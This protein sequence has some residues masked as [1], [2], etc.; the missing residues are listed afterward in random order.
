M[1]Q[2]QPQGRP[3]S[4]PDRLIVTVA[5]A[6]WIAGTLVG[7]G[8][9]GQAPDAAQGEGLFSDHA[10][11]LAPYRPAFSIWPVIYVFLAGY[12]VWQWLPVAARSRWAAATRWPAAASLALNGLWLVVVYQGWIGGSVVVMAALLVS[13]GVLVL[14]L[15]ALP[16]EG[17]SS[18]VFLGATFGLYLGW[19]CVAT[20]ANIESWLAAL[21][22][23][24]GGGPATALAAGII[25]LVVV[26]ALAL[27][28]R[29][30]HPVTRWAFV[31]A[32]VW[33][34]AWVAVGRLRG[35]LVNGVVSVVAVIAAVMVVV[36]A[37]AVRA[38]RTPTPQPRS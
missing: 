20:G 14:R 33:G 36:M 32:V 7:M 10:T 21:G 25:A 35:I 17:W 3:T 30:P 2:G 27:L 22:V 4:V 31:A 9:V 24:Q 23:A 38:D 29:T 16:P 6:V 34:L 1:T 19:I 37:A 28:R 18:Q 13:L 11:L 8:W 12:V 15:D 5:A 26:I